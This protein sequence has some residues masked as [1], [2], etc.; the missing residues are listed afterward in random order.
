MDRVENQY[1][2]ASKLNARAALHGR[3]GT[4]P[5]P[6]QRWVFDRFDLP[7]ETRILELGCGPGKLWRENAD[8]VPEGWAV[9]LTDASPGMVEEAKQNLGDR[10]F[11]F[12][13]A[14]AQALP[15][16][17]RSFDAVVANH[18]LY[19]VPDRRKAFSEI[20]RVLKTEGVLYAATND[21]GS[22]QE[23][24]R[25]LRFLEP[26]HSQDDTLKALQNFSL[27]NGAEL[28]SRWFSEV[29]LLRYED[30]LSVTEAEP[31][32]DYVVS[33]MAAREISQRLPE[34]EFRARVSRL[35][36]ALE[37]E[38]VSHGT[39]RITKDTGMFAARR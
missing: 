10:S 20:T 31:L 34:E 23:L 6:W 13:V 39:I 8:R 27:E 1:R 30:D 28:L 3:F 2:D 19:H 29:S 37:R 36:E 4:N 5:H 7:A 9:T 14:D 12:R 38:L 24:G 33:M 17:D 25:M 35:R 15:F 16:A 11:D 22:M 26:G 32:V 21:E 18:V